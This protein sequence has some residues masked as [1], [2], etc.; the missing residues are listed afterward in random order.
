MDPVNN[1]VA[2]SSD[3]ANAV[4]VYPRTANGDVPPLRK[5]QGDKTQILYPEAVFIDTVN[6]EL[7]VNNR[8][9]KSILFFSRTAN[10]NVA[11]LRVIRGRDTGIV[12]AYGSF[13]NTDTGEYWTINMSPFQKPKAAL[14]EYE[15]LNA[16]AILVFSRTANGNVA[17]LRRIYGD[18]TTLGDP[19]TFAFD[20]KHNE[21][22]LTS[23]S[24]EPGKDTRS[25]TTLE[26]LVTV[27][28]M[29]QTGNV[30]PK[31]ILKSNAFALPAGIFVS[32]EHDEIGILE[33]RDNMI[34]VFPRLW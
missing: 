4:Y 13:V 3:L 21:I 14:D 17:P 28:D 27:F 6:N 32:P 24:V 7:V 2:A 34:M 29:R 23:F 16:P 10:G 1:E 11:P 19:F 18:K 33:A 22:F 9:D 25:P 12:D 15:R 26:G 31:R 8:G 20:V 30:P 5:I